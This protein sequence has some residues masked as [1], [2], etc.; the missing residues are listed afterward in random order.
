MADLHHNWKLW[1]NKLQQE[2]ETRNIKHA[3]TSFKDSE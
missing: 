3:M 1:G 2:G